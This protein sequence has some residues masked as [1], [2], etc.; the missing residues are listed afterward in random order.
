MGE[1]S[2]KADRLDALR[3]LGPERLATLLARVPT[4]AEAVDGR[5]PLA[6]WAF[7]YWSPPGKADTARGLAEL[8]ASRRGVDATLSCL[9]RFELQVVSLAVWH[10]GRVTLGEAL[11]EVGGEHHDAL[12]DAARS[13]AGLLLTDPD[14]GWVALRP[15]VAQA[16][17]LP[18]IPAR[19]SLEATHSNTLATMLRAL[20]ARDVPRLKAERVDALEAFLRDPEALARVLDRLDEDALRVFKILAEHGPQ[21][22]ADL[23]LPRFVPWSTIDSPLRRLAGLALVGVNTDSQVAWVWLDVVVGLSGGLFADWDPRPPPA[24]L[25]PLAQAGVAL[26][27]APGR[28]AALLAEWAA[29]PAPALASGGLGVRP[30]RAAAKTLGLPPGEVGLLAHLAIELGLLGTIVVDTKGRGRT[31]TDVCAWAPTALAAHFAGLTPA[32]RWALL[33]QAWRHDADH[34][35]AEGLPERSADPLLDAHLSLRRSTLLD[36]L[37]ELPDGQG[38]EEDDLVAHAGFARPYDLHAPAVRG[39]VAAARVLGLVPPE[40]PVGLTA[41]ARALLAGGVDA[42]EDALPAPRTDFIVQADHTVVAPPDLDAELAARLERYADLE[43]AAGA[44]TYR[45]SE[46]RLAGAL[47]AGETA[48]EILAFL[49]GHATAPLAQNV[50]YLVRD[51]ERRHGRLRAGEARAYLRCDDPALL[52]TAVAARP[53]KLRLLAPT[54][55]VSSLGRDALVS[56]L[57]QRGL[58]PRAEDADGTVLDTTAPPA[59]PELAAAHALPPLEPPRAGGDG[60]VERARALLDAPDREAADSELLAYGT[61]GRDLLERLLTGEL[62]LIDDFG[63]FDEDAGLP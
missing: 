12:E 33:V 29:Q 32:R 36:L 49:A 43:S 59:A 15:G 50:E 44:R 11:A 19:P 14:A 56:V 57:R 40:G 25:Q 37:A 39:L 5:G 7:G 54:V 34:D 16:A 13:L 18:G 46:R 48:E 35:D 53:A 28:L 8:L 62:D 24:R 23:G 26:P 55:A 30:V 6:D 38:L 3:A 20:G 27:P 41:A 31:R 58:M 1:P 2:L 21:S 52:S 51:I 17:G 47:D 10:G 4:L 9:N 63:D 22:I 61:L 42:V 45:L 60:L